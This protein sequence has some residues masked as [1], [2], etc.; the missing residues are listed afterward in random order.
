[1]VVMVLLRAG[2]VGMAMGGGAVGMALLWLW[3]SGSTR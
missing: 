1:V 3:S 2:A